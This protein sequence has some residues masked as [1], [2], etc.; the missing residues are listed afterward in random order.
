MRSWDSIPEILTVHSYIL[1]TWS[2]DECKS[3]CKH[4]GFFCANV[5]NYR[6]AVITSYECPIFYP[7]FRQKGWNLRLITISTF[8]IHFLYSLWFI[9]GNYFLLLLNFPPFC[10]FY[11]YIIPVLSAE[12]DVKAVTRNC[13]GQHVCFLLSMRSRYLHFQRKCFI[14]N[15]CYKSKRTRSKSSIKYSVAA[16]IMLHVSA[17]TMNWPLSL[18]LR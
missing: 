14:S 10:F 7:L 18:P 8:N 6:F 2:G 15:D 17:A 11:P 3:P 13:F 1:I 4:W 5:L 12:D 16:I 9:T